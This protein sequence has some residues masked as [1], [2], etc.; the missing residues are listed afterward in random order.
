MII[1][2]I[3]INVSDFDR[4]YKFYTN[5][6]G[7]KTLRK[8]QRKAYLYLGSDMIELKQST[9]PNTFVAPDTPEGWRK[10]MYETVKIGHIGLRVDDIDAALR[11]IESRGG[12]IV[13]PPYRFEPE[14]AADDAPD[15]DKLRRA[16]TPT[17]KPYWMIA[18]IADPDGIL[19][20]LLER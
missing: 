7:F 13:I 2:H 19:F 3:G 1:E 5:V 6:L 11:Q 18:V 12:E 10:Q 16:A 20:E 8:S 14:A 17:N 9:S 4:S 15:D